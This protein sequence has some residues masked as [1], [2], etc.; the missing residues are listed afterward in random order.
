M[1]RLTE[2]ASAAWLNADPLWYKDAVIYQLHIKSF[3][4]ANGDGVG[5]FAGLS[6]KLDYL[7][8]LGVDTVWLL[9]FYP[10]P[11]RD[12]GYD[13]ADYRNVHPDYGTMSE[14][15]RFVAAAHARSLRVIT[16]LV[17]NHTSDQHPWFQRARRAKPGSAA[18]NY[19][20][21][22]DSDQTYAGTRIIFCDTEK[23]N[24][25]WDP[26]AGAY[27]WHRFYSHQ[28]DLNFDNPQVLRE[29]MSVMRFWLDIGVDGLRLD[30]VPYLVEREGTS[31]ENLPETHT[32]IKQI[33][34]HL[35]A[36]YSGRILLAEANMWPED[37]QQYF[38]GPGAPA[39][40][41]SPISPALTG[42]ASR[43]PPP[44]STPAAPAMQSAGELSNEGTAELGDECHMSFHFPLMPRMYMAI[45]REDRFPI[46][47]IM[48][49]TPEI[50]PNCQWAIFLR[51][52]DELTLEMVTSA[53]RD[54][55]WEV[56]ASD[57]RARINLGIR[58]RL[59]PLMERDR[60]R[61]ELMNSLLFSMPGTPVIYY[62][63]EIGM[64]DNIHLGDR[65][66]VRTP[67][68]WSPD[69]NGGFSHADPERLVLP[70]LQ[71]PLYGYDAVNVE[72]QTRDPH[73]LL[74]WMRRML[75]LRR[76]HRA[77]GRGTLRFL[78]P[79]NR[80]ILAYLREFE[81]EHIL[82]VANLARAPQ[83][84]ELDLS[85]FAGRVP[86]EMM[87]ATP[88]PAIGQ[89]T[90]LLTLPPYGFYWFVLS[91]EAQPPSWHVDAPEQ[92]PDQITLVLHSA[93]HAE[94]TEASRRTLAN[95]VLPHY[96]GRRRWYGSKG[97]RIGSVAI[98]Y[99]IPF[100][101]G[102]AGDETYLCEME[103]ALDSRAE[104]YQLPLGML[105]DRDDPGEG[106]SQLAHSLSMG[107]VRKGSRVG[108]VTD[109]FAVECFAREVVRALRDGLA[110]P[111][112]R[113]PI[114]FLAEPGLAALPLETDEIQ[115]V[116][117]EQSNSSLSFDNSAVLKLVRRIAAGI[118]PEAEVTR[119]L[120]AQ[121]Y[122]NSAPLLGEVVRTG[123]DGEP[124]T[125]ML[126]QGYI[127]NQ[128]DAWGWTL[129]YLGR[130]IDDAVP[131]EDSEE[132]FAEALKGY[133]TVAGTLGQRLAELH[134]VLAC[135]TD[136]AAFAPEPAGDAQARL[137]AEEAMAE[138]ART[139]A[140]LKKR[141]GELGRASRNQRFAADIETLIKARAQLPQL[142]AKLAAA[143]P[144]SLQTRIHG[145][146]H[147]GQVLIAQ[148]D[149]YLVDFEGEPG[150]P[151]DW[152]RRKTSPLRDVAG[153]LRS[154]DYAAA[155]VGTDRHER[156]HAALPPS[157]TQRREALLD[158]FRQ[159]AG[160][161]FLAGYWQVLAAAPQPWVQPE[162]AQAL[163]DLFLLERAAYEVGYEAANRVA[164]IDLPVNGLARL[165]RKLTGSPEDGDEQA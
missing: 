25:S 1:K 98:A 157:Q 27:F 129:D 164:W 41:I 146:F 51:N 53:E 114:R 61:I 156:T 159:T 10:S 66:G 150:L 162:Q 144:G 96:I 55:L 128:G 47:D 110:L 3:Y 62:G 75:A 28:P 24:W 36:E 14:A 73:S 32:V 115:W 118:H 65:D 31:N 117:A 12:D 21:W 11:R 103:L 120:T 22:S 111:S 29:V 85:A 49:Q 138:L 35:D 20:V 107:R 67:M 60:R 72:A 160:D 165:V 140:L 137:W 57:R 38:G 101:Q 161:A 54:Y 74:N 100:G 88:F 112:P 9:P 50:P 94:L 63:D 145:D 151:L 4:D 15:R 124:R 83:A 135:P 48:R 154:L 84:V 126:L 8:N 91:E 87:G 121:G 64:G 92:M 109:G 97:E 163:L 108:L 95:E 2:P 155:T 43:A 77:F 70:P 89:L 59:A 127:L 37:A 7:V 81:G 148:N 105:W 119:Y 46:T 99:A 56:Y 130:A 16:E 26:V 143:A 139:V 134:A 122:R 149:T 153:L 123:E 106:A 17:I 76:Q 147:L 125:L 142:V 158:R 42:Q 39:A 102:T 44:V 23:S 141:A 79:G 90:Y 33:R 40:S 132:E 136:D 131:S 52:H 58:R 82:C 133:A 45:A 71:G 30:A 104:C 68:Q 80:K 5:D 19:Y 152:R 93:A 6:A 69:R 18:R 34:A 116:S 78:F 113:G 86:V 13:I